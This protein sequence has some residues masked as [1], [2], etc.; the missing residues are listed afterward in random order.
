M[1]SVGDKMNK[2]DANLESMLETFIFESNTLLE[3]LD[4]ILLNSE[5]TNVM[6]QEDINEIFRIM[7]TIKGSAAMMG[8]EN[9]S[10][11]AHRIEDMFFIIRDNKDAASDYS[12]IYDIVFQGSDFIKNEIETIQDESTSP[13][14]PDELIVLIEDEIEFIKSGKTKQKNRKPV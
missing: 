14:D 10:V 5:K 3:Q 11:V 4:G 7:H 1:Y 13:K 9:V 6:N 2:F 12:S 8:I